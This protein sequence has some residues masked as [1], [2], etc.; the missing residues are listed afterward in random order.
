MK[1]RFLLD[2]IVRESA[3]ILKLLAGEDQTLL[4]RGDAF[5][6]LNLGLDIVNGIRGLDLEGN[7]LPSQSLYENLHS[8]TE[9][10]HKVQRG[11]LLNVIVG[12]RASIFQLFTSEDEALLI[13]GNSELVL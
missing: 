7:G 9:T 11:F 3:T 13:R 5:L 8:A 4:I 10:K 1:G 2:V 12:K 6:V